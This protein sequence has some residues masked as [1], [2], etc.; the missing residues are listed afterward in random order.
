MRFSR[1]LGDNEDHIAE[2]STGF[3]FEIAEVTMN[4]GLRS[5]VIVRVIG[6]HFGLNEGE[7]VSQESRKMWRQ[8]QKKLTPAKRLLRTAFTDS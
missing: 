6:A 5:L 3:G 7:S 8:W 4:E 2:I 1:G